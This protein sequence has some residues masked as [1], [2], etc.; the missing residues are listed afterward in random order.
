[1]QTMKVARKSEKQK[2]LSY[3]DD[4]Y[5]FQQAWVSGKEEQ[6]V[7]KQE[8][9]LQKLQERRSEGMLQM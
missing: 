7:S 6:E 2:L 3:W 9:W 4:G 1:M 8:R 5:A